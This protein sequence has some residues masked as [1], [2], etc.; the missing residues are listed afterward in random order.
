[1]M[2]CGGDGILMT[3]SAIAVLSAAAAF[4]V[5]L[6]VMEWTADAGEADGPT[7]VGSK[8]CKMCHIPHYKSWEKTKMGRALDILKPNAYSDKKVAAGL[9]P[10]KDYT[11]DS[12]CLKCHT[13]GFGQ[14]GGYEVPDPSDKKAVRRAKRLAHVGCESC[15]GPGSE[16][17][18]LHKE[19][20]MESRPYKSE[21]M[22]AAG[23][24]KIGP[25]VCTKCHNAENPTVG[26]D[27]VFDYQKLKDQDHHKHFALKLRQD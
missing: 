20:M 1:M 10:S 12:T 2:A 8:S 11:T 21:E 26:P 5:G 4:G 14:P 23:M 16:Y 25:E 19:I 3:R 18:V 24:F 6:I 17:V 7:Y 9:D 22:Y 15:H 13:V 27:D